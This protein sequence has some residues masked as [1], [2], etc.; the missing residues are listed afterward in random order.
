MPSSSG[1]RKEA[2]EAL[3][4]D[5]GKRL[6][7][8]EGEAFEIVARED[9]KPEWAYRTPRGSLIKRPD[10]TDFIWQL[11]GGAKS[12]IQKKLANIGGELKFPKKNQ[13]Y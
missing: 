9:G 5:Y 4:I 11:F 7:P 10:W 8:I 1:E 12:R 6:G 13:P 2:A 3:L